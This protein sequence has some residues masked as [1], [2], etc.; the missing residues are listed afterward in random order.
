MG[1]F[2]WACSQPPIE[3]E[4]SRYKLFSRSDTCVWEKGIWANKLSHICLLCVVF[5]APPKTPFQTPSYLICGGHSKGKSKLSF[6]LFCGTIYS[7]TLFYFR[8]RGNPL[9]RKGPPPVA[10][11]K[12][13]KGERRRYIYGKESLARPS[14]RLERILARWKL[15]LFQE[16]FPA[17]SPSQHW[18]SWKFY[19]ICLF[20]L[21]PSRA[22][23]WKLAR[24]LVQT[25]WNVSLLPRRVSA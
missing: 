21:S 13:E 1:E 5:P 20:I 16:P 23:A 19:F 22:T 24:K 25:D 11:P 9:G 4:G 12:E 17:G 15:L 7:R 18:K 3:K 8:G 10:L 14:V 6:L 2:R